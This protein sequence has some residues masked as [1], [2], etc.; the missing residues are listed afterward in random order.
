MDI[1]LDIEG[2]QL[3]P[4]ISN[5]W[6]VCIKPIGEKPF[7]IFSSNELELWIEENKPHKII[8]H[9][10]LGFDL[11]ALHKVWGIPYVLDFMGKDNWNGDRTEF[12]DTLQLS[13]FLNPDRS[14]GHSLEDW[15]SRLGYPK[16]NFND[17]SK[18]SDEMIEYCLR[19]TEV[20]E[21]VYNHLLKEAEESN[22]Q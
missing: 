2:D 1:I 4:G 16:G 5:I 14:W 13:Q 9:N 18:L 3:L 19:D 11:P 7:P 20:T 17:W 8:G 6:V 21:L 10:I 15:G 22:D 12:I